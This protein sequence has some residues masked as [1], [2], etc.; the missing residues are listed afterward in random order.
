[1]S[2][3][4]C[5]AITSSHCAIGSGRPR[6]KPHADFQHGLHAVLAEPKSWDTREAALALCFEHLTARCVCGE[7][8]GCA[9]D[10]LD[11]PLVGFGSLV[12]LV[13]R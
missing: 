9:S 5:V 3:S 13:V 7:G 11:H 8:Q 6:G 2:V 12:R 10:K 4:R 1:M